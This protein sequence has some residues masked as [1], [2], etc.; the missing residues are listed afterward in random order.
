MLSINPPK[1]ANSCPICFLPVASPHLGK[2]TW[3]SSANRSRMLAPLEV[4]PLLSNAFRYSIATDLRC[5]SV[6]VCFVIA[7]RT[8][9][10]VFAGKPDT[11][12]HIYSCPE[13][14]DVEKSC[15]GALGRGRAADCS[16]PPAQIRTSG[17]THT[18]C[19]YIIVGLGCDGKK[20]VLAC[21]ARPGRENL[22]D[23]KF[24]QRGLIERG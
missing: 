7:I 13:H 9:L 17:F 16:T 20:Q 15:S 10:E 8:V 1:S 6:M 19:I 21:M 12:S 22:E 3:A 24:I 23:W 18:A 5:S 11:I 14:F 2:K 4:T